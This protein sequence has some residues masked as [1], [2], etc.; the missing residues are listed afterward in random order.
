MRL[1]VYCWCQSVLAAPW[2]D[3]I[4]SKSL[5]SNCAPMAVQLCLQK[6]G[7]H[8]NAVVLVVDMHYKQLLHVALSR[9]DAQVSHVLQRDTCPAT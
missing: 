8:G 2:C 7:A 9:V 3:Y 1:Q 5:L 6:R 4:Y